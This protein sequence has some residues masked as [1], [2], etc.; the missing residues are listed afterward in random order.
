MAK[1]IAA[2]TF[3]HLPR[4]SLHGSPDAL[5]AIKASAA[6]AKP[7]V[8]ASGEPILGVPRRVAQLQVRACIHVLIA[9]K[10]RNHASRSI[11]AYP[12]SPSM[13]LSV[14]AAATVARLSGS[15]VI[16]CTAWGPVLPDPLPGQPHDGRLEDLAAAGLAAALTFAG[17]NPAY[18]GSSTAT[19]AMV[20]LS[21]PLTVSPLRPST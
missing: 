19:A 2:S 16:V 18:S 13:R 3:D 11:I 15:S 14:A 20:F 7:K 21:L 12:R 8:I 1:S 9:A 17:L 5:S 4:G 10:A 6:S